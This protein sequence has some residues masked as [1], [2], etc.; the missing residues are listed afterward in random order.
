MK[1]KTSFFNA[2]IFKKNISHY[3][4]VWVVFLCYLIFLLPVRIWSDTA[5]YQSYY[6]ETG[7]SAAA[8]QYQVIGSVI[9][10]AVMPIPYFIFALVAAL[11]VFSYL[12]N[13]RTAN[14]IHAL[15]VNRFELFVTNYISGILFLIIPELIAFVAAV[16]VSLVNQ[17]TVIEYL[18]WW[19][20]CTMGVS[21]FAYSMA[22]FVAMFTGLSIAMPFYYI[23]VNYLYVGCYYLIHTVEQK[24]CY[25]LGDSSWDPGRSCM[26]SPMY[27]MNNNLRARVVY[28]N[29]GG[30]PTGIFITGGHLVTGYVIVGVVLVVL[31][32]RLYK[33]RQLECAGDLISIRIVKPL[34]RWGMSFCCGILFALFVTSVIENARGWVN[35]YACMLISMLI[36]CAIFFWVAEMLLQKNFRVFSK[37]R[38]AEWTVIAVM[39]VGFLTLFEFDAFKIERKLPQENEVEMAFVNM[40]F[41][42]E[43]AQEDLSRLLSIHRQIIDSKKVYQKN[44]KDPDGKYY[45]TTIRYYLKNGKDI[46]RRYAIPV[47]EEYLSDAASPVAQI[48][49]WE[50][51]P[52]CMKKQILGRSYTDNRYYAGSIDLYSD[53]G[54]AFTY[55]FEPEELEEIED[56]VMADIEEGNFDMYQIMSTQSDTDYYVNG[57]SLLYY[58]QHSQYD[59]WDY[60]YNYREYKQQEDGKDASI[61]FTKT[62]DSNRYI[63]FGP[64]CKHTIETLKKLGITDEKW[65]LF[66]RAAYDKLEAEM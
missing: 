2:T 32:Y 35:N 11:V 51:D 52:E 7:M 64:E 44:E 40:D 50:E 9:R 30:F 15:P 53:A 38:L 65:K 4:P 23:I 1:S 62:M 54:D 42:I 58:N 8:T 14:T 21:F 61:S 43:V 25:G 41:P 39:S 47:T 18:F 48:I 6:A 66:T 28:D 60:C 37:K 46:E 20:L 29:E 22:V 57:L 36:G 27:Y 10:G 24:L 55:Y 34:F 45:Y 33:R 31:A 3:W 19:L 59:M 12:Y 56:A 17:V 5:D 49:S 13:A 26:L 63:S 16:I